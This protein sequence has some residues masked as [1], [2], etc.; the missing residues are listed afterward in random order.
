MAR[1]PTV[2]GDSNAWG[3]IL[4]D[5]L[6]VAH[7][8][9]GS[10]KTLVSVSDYGASPSAAASVND[11]AIAAAIA[12][13]TTAGSGVV[14]F[15]AGVYKISVPI[16]V[17]HND[18]HLLGF[19]Q[20]GATQ[21]TVDSSADPTYALIVGNTAYINDCS[22]V[23]ISFFGRNTTT[24]TGGGINLRS[25]AG[26][27]RH[28]QV[29]Y[30]G[31]TGVNVA[32]FTASPIFEVFFEDVDLVQN[33]MNATTP[34]DNL[35]IAATA[36]DCEYHRV[37]ATGDVTKSTTR[38][39]FNNNGAGQQK[40]YDCHA[41]WAHNDGFLNAGGSYIF[42][43]E[44]ENCTGNGIEGVG[45]LLVV[46]AS[47][48]GNGNTDIGAYGPSQIIG[49]NCSSSTAFQNIYVNSAS[50]G[51]IADNIL[52][53]ATTNAILLDTG[54]ANYSVHDN[55]CAQALAAT[56]GTKSTNSRIHDNTLTA[57]GISEQTGANNNDIHDNSIASGKTI[58][59]V[60]TGTKVKNNPGY[61]P[62]GFSVTQPAVPASTVAVTNTTGCDCDVLIKGGTLTVINVGGSATGITAAA[63]AGSVHS[64]R[65][66]AG[67]TIS[68]TYTVAPTWTW[69]GD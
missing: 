8:A 31:G 68:I 48:F 45:V 23:G 54:A 65:V 1:L 13:V 17:D 60:G 47:L 46:G 28:V 33:G 52:S 55:Q 64:V 5:F 20:R 25:Y 59:I 4:N 63:A 19:A 67:Q 14:Y 11:T 9:D 36:S 32:S 18:I 3:S 38:N 44:F 35:L 21:I 58:T 34:G 6:S 16:I 66:P 12:V 51:I 42:G 15:P 69:F 29:A 2:S 22:V 30:F 40:F 61:N 7:N 39:C 50:G 26:A 41:Y 24:S 56:I 49:C 27:L 53:G 10:L 57:G 37:I 62:R 43:G